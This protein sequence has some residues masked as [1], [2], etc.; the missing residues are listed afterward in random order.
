MFYE[1]ISHQT[2]YIHE[3]QTVANL[4]LKEWANPGPFFVYFRS[5]QTNNTIF[6]NKSMWKNVQLSIQY[7]VP[8]FEPTFWTRVVT[9][10]Q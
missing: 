8:G 1:S 9:H 6:Y 10:N 3:T 7:T 2:F 5:F 4:F